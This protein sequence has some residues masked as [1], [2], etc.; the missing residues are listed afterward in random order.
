[1]ASFGDRIRQGWNAFLG[2]DPTYNIYNPDLGSGSFRR[3][4]RVKILPGSEHTI[5]TAIYNRI[6]VDVASLT[7][8]HAMVDEN[9]KFKEDCDDD[10]NQ[11]LTVEAN[12]DQTGRELIRD[13][14]IGIMDEGCI[15]VVPTITTGA[16]DPTVSDSYKIHELRVGPVTQW[17]PR[18]VR[19]KLYNE[20]KGRKEEVILPKRMVA[21]IENPFY[22]IMNEPNS[23]LRRLTRKLNLLDLMDEQNSAR[24]LDLV[25]QL[26]Y[27]VKTPA[28]EK[29]ANA[30]RQSII[31]QLTKS[32]LGI[33]YIDGTEK[34][35]QLNRAVETTLPE[36]IKHLQETLYSQLG[37]T[38]EIMNGT[39][40]ETTMLNYYSRTVEPI[41]DAI[42]DEFN[43]KFLTKTARTQ[44]HAII[45]LRDPFKLVPISQLAD[46]LDKLKRNEMITSNE[47]RALIGLKPDN[48]ARANELINSNIN[49]AGDTKKL[50]GANDAPPVEEI[51]DA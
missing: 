11:C 31:D 13:A 28:R 51:E 29:Q 17:Y 8:R 43:R 20:D 44:G 27:I 24:K 30:R 40:N 47:G 50:T 23:T 16:N 3:P 21:I 18:D 48:S 32:D 10:L 25:I 1:M 34:I 4:D 26:P 14:A 12:V 36:E 38:P 49:P 46:I 39:A 35:T 5:I 33:A 9:K 19:I 37:I 2:R 15:A 6:A 7:F 42:V 22:S 45:Y 41:A